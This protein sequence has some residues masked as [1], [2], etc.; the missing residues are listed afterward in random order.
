MVAS[1]WPHGGIHP[2]PTCRPPPGEHDGLQL[3]SNVVGISCRH[4]GFQLTKMAATIWTMMVAAILCN[5]VISLWAK[6]YV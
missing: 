4:D 3:A 5:K 6:T 1:T 2:G